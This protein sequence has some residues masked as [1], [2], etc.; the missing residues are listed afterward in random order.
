MSTKRTFTPEQIAEMKK[1]KEDYNVSWSLVGKRFGCSHT[2]VKMAC[3]PEYAA[4]VRA[5][6][7]ARD[8]ASNRVPEK[9]GSELFVIPAHVIADRE[10]R[11]AAE[12][13]SLGSMVMGEPPIGYSALD[14]MSKA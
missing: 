5:R 12:Y 3:E 10:R 8:R 9:T 14:R 1:M 11:L 2:L 13:R 7:A 6:E 4:L